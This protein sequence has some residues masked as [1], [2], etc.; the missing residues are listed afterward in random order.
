MSP[1]N[2]ESA[3]EVWKKLL[4]AKL[5]ALRVHALENDATVQPEGVRQIRDLNILLKIQDSL[6]P[7][8]PPKRWPI[9]LVFFYTFL[10]ISVL[11]F[12]HVRHTRIDFDVT[13]TEITFTLDAASR[14]S[15]PVVLNRASIQGVT[16]DP[17][18][19]WRCPEPSTVRS[20]TFEAIGKPSQA[21]DISVDVL[22]L[23]KGT[24][25]TISHPDA[26][27]KED[28]KIE[29]PKGDQDL[30]VSFTAQGVAR[31][32]S[33]ACSSTHKVAAFDQLTFHPVAQV[34]NL[35]FLPL[36]EGTPRSMNLPVSAVSLSRVITA[37]TSDGPSPIRL[38]T[39]LTGTIFF[40]S[41]GGRE[42]KLREGERIELTDFR[43]FL[44]TLD[45]N[46]DRIHT[47]LTGDVA[48]LTSGESDSTLKPTCFEYIMT[49]H[50]LPSFWG[51]IIYCFG[52]FL[53]FSRWWSSKS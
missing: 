22:T 34:L 29:L 39:I 16:L 8:A 9:A 2:V 52:L 36:A 47:R 5:A 53:A 6:Q 10:V 50:S 14:L 31:L 13:A 40:D 20:F 21:E 32:Q 18:D 49:N 25:V 4:K 37:S 43:G 46:K 42:R 24:T 12:S 7:S 30:L 45:A 3:S 44:H 35:S 41:I 1:D 19:G 17:Q 15:P 51:A 27:L 26:S 23:P 33:G 48:D 38:S 28:W 11:F